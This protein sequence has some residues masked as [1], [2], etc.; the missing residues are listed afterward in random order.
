MNSSMDKNESKFSYYAFICYTHA[1][2]KEAK[3]LFDFLYSYRL[4]SKLARLKKKERRL[5]PHFLDVDEMPSGGYEEVDKKA[6]RE[7]KYLIVI[8]SKNLHAHDT[9]VNNEI[10]DFLAYGNPYDHIIPFIVDYAENPEKECFPSA[11]IE[12]NKEMGINLIG[13]NVF[14]PDKSRHDRKARIKV[15]AKMHGLNPAELET[16]DSRRRVK[17][18]IAAVVMFIF[19]GISSLGLWDYLHQPSMDF[20]VYNEVDDW[21]AVDKIDAGVGDVVNYR[22]EVDNI[23][24]SDSPFVFLELDESLKYESGYVTTD[25]L[26]S[27]DEIDDEIIANGLDLRKFSESKS[28]YICFSVRVMNNGLSLSGNELYVKAYFTDGDKKINKYNT[29]NVSFSEQN[30]NDDEAVTGW[31][32]SNG[33]R[34]VYTESE[35]N[36]Q[37]VLENRIVLNSI[38]DSVIGDERNFVRARKSSGINAGLYNVWDGNIVEFTEEGTYIISVYVHNDNP[39]G[40]SVTAKDVR[41]NVIMPKESGRTLGVSCILESS[42]AEPSRYWDGVTFKSNKDFYIDYVEG[43]AILENNGIGAGHGYRLSDDI[44][45]SNGVMLGYDSMDGNIPGGYQ[46]AAYVSFE[47]KVVFLN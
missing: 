4:P 7:S 28:V 43:S 17:K 22:I 23:N 42:N 27:G 13:L 18:S 1:D 25:I 45:T 8:C 9:T 20:L 37:N 36:N 41:A 6:L 29:V 34:E 16:E 11:I 14:S 10:R 32:D 19:L 39:K 31:G 44:I 40:Q 30:L 21:E 5:M 12:M 46:Y 2:Y 47:V 38:T 35:V 24:Y 15:M 26:E 33:G 3:R